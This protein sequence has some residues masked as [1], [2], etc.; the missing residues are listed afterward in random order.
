MLVV[1]ACSNRDTNGEG[2]WVYFENESYT[3]LL[4]DNLEI[5]FKDTLV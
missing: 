1:Y 2:Y 5:T 3:V 4:G